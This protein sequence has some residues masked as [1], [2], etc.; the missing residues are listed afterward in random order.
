[1]NKVSFSSQDALLRIREIAGDL[2]DS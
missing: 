2:A 1:V